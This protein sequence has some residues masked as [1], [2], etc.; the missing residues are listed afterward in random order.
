MK[1]LPCNRPLR[2]GGE[3]E[4]EVRDGAPALAPL[5]YHRA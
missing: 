3:E 1:S 4:R 2:G 5:S